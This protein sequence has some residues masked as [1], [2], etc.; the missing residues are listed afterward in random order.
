MFLLLQIVLLTSC[1]SMQENAADPSGE[2][3]YSPALFNAPNVAYFKFKT[4]QCPLEDAQI[5][6]IFQEQEGVEN[7]KYDPLSS[8]CRV[9][10]QKGRYI[11]FDRFVD[12]AKKLRQKILEV[13]I[14][15]VGSLEWLENPTGGEP[16]SGIVLPDTGETYFLAGGYEPRGKSNYV[17]LQQGL[18]AHGKSMIRFVGSLHKGVGGTA[19]AVSVKWYRIKGVRGK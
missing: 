2:I 10:F 14:D 4:L 8:V 18:K 7:F 6:K 9:T 1:A 5:P 13:N 17:K 3:A 11:K 15:F 16:V 12:L 19:D